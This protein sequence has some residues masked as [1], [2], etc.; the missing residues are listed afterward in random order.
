MFQCGET[1]G[2]NDGKCYEYVLHEIRNKLTWTSGSKKAL[3]LFGDDI[4]HPTDFPE[5]TLRLD[6]KTE[7]DRLAEEKV[8][9]FIVLHPQPC[10]W[11]W[12]AVW[13]C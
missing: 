4:P 12:K 6:W 2:G 8:R 7:A 1:Q 5:N 3:I 13:M 10:L 9:C 11:T